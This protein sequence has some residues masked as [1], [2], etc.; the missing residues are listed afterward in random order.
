MTFESKQRT[1]V[2]FERSYDDVAVAVGNVER[3]WW[4]GITSDRRVDT[5]SFP[6]FFTTTTHRDE[7]YCRLRHNLTNATD[8]RLVNSVYDGMEECYGITMK[9]CEI[10]PVS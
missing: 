1:W 9:W 10:E 7:F 3:R 6:F 5:R 8:A 2:R 4:F